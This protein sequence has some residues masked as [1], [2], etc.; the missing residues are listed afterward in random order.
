MKIKTSIIIS[1][2]F[3][4]MIFFIV[5]LFFQYHREKEYKNN[6]LNRTLE[7]INNDIFHYMSYNSLFILDSFIQKIEAPDIRI[8]IIDTQGIVIYDNKIKKFL[9]LENHAHRPEIIT[10]KNNAVGVDIRFSSTTHQ[11]Y[12]YVAKK[13]NNIYIRASLPYDLSWFSLFKLNNS[14]VYIIFLITIF[15][16]T[17]FGYILYA[18]NVRANHRQIQKDAIIRRRLTQQIAHELKTPLSAIVG[19]VEILKNQ[20]IPLEKKHYFL[21][22][23]LLQAQSL[24]ALLEDILLLY[25]IDDASQF[26][27][28][29]TVCLNDILNH[30]IQDIQISLHKKK[31]LINN[32]IKNPI[33]L[34]GNK[35]L[36]YSIFFNL[37]NNAIAYAGEGTSIDI[38]LFSEDH[39]VYT[40]LL[41]D[42]GIG[43]QSSHLK[44][45]FERFYRVD[46]GRSRSAGGT[47]LGLSI[48]KNAVE[49]HKGNIQ[50]LNRQTGGLEFIIRLPKSKI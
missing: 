25:K 23:C 20:N 46:K 38:K 2:V 4:V 29:E 21:D 45:I 37:L 16:V 6:F 36:L 15:L 8:T 17:L 12:Y 5:A 26:Y 10:A 41:Y 18:M 7:N 11:P 35:M 32:Q 28:M 19:Y 43:I 39:H 24:N 42:N 3:A 44:H 27:V 9:S 47:G 33:Y 31:M 13:Y 48:V 22:R 30:I 14:Y 50:V 40:L 34:Q 49:I 1:Y